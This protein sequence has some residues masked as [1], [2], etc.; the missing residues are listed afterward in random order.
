M[1]SN[2]QLED[3][4]YAGF[5][6]SEFNSNKKSRQKE[7]K[8]TFPP[9]EYIPPLQKVQSWYTDIFTDLVVRLNRNKSHFL[10]STLHSG[11]INENLKIISIITIKIIEAIAIFK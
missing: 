2:W 10:K 3:F 9:F 5:Q 8:H 6:L 11:L 7:L 1:W 4:E